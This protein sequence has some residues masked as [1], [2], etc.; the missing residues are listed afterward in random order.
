M[1]LEGLEEWHTV[2]ML[3]CQCKDFGFY[4]ECDGEPWQGLSRA[5]QDFTQYFNKLTVAA[6]REQGQKESR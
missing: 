1:R 3:L 6:L 4:S 2:Q 5:A